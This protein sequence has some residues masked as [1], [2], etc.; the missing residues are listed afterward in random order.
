M[1]QE[2]VMVLFSTIWNVLDLLFLLKKHAD[3]LG[4]HT[5]QLLPR[6]HSLTCT[7]TSDK[8]PQPWA[9]PAVLPASPAQCSQLSVS[10]PRASNCSLTPHCWSLPGGEQTPLDQCDSVFSLLD[11]IL[12][13][14][15]CALASLVLLAN[16]RAGLFSCDFL[17]KAVSEMGPPQR[18]CPLQR[19]YCLLGVDW[20]FPSPFLVYI[21][22]IGRRNLPAFILTTDWGGVGSTLSNNLT[23]SPQIKIWKLLLSFVWLWI[24]CSEVYAQLVFLSLE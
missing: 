21:I 9:D 22:L 23:G 19:G 12:L 24:A 17:A 15:T 4:M 1:S 5:A 10:H 11:C 18:H 16:L 13:L 8:G 3:S 20:I 14:S 2:S 7:P 6:A